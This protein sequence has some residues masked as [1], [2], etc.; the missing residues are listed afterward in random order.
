[1]GHLLNDADLIDRIFS[2]IDGKTTDAGTQVWREPVENYRSRERFDAEIEVLRRIPVPFCPSAALSEPGSYIARTAARTP[3]LVVRGDDGVARAFRNACRHRGM[4]VA[5][6]EGCQRS[7]ACHYHA[8]TYGLDGSLKHVPG[9]DGF[10]GLDKADNGLVPVHAVEERG[11][12]IFVTQDTPLSDGALGE[13]PDLL[14][15]GQEVFNSISFTDESNWKLIGETSMEGYHIKALHNKSFYPYGFDNLNV[16]ETYGRNSRIVF[17]FRRIEKLRQIPR[18]ERRLKGMVTDVYQ[19]FPNTHISYLTD[20]AMLVILEP[21]SPTETQWVI[22]QVTLK[23]EDGKPIDVEVARRDANFVQDTG[24]IE[25]RD[26]AHTIQTHMESGANSHLTFGHFEQ[27]IGHFHR[28]LT[29]HVD[30]LD[31]G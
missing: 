9:E 25:D 10:P 28:N 6:G 11:G 30:M 21:V 26:A 16:V 2:H 19:L 22:Y 7:F 24:L 27:A 14:E 15:P 31:Q 18:E 12:L 17:P 5:R 1:M 3:L 29:A 8:W 4:A 20:H 13:M 23:P